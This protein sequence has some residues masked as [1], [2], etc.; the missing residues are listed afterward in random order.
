MEED[1]TALLS[2]GV[3]VP[4]HWRRQPILQDEFPYINL[5]MVSAPT[6]YVL[7]GEVGAQE[8]SVQVDIWA[9][10]YSDAVIL[11]RTVSAL[12]SGASVLE[13]TTNFQG[14][15]KEGEFDRDG[16]IPQASGNRQIFGRSADYRF[17]FS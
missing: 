15:F 1:F 4:V 3:A 10:K 9:E 5:T 14:F 17:A 2:A 7:E 8:A 16:E 12:L 11:S 13:G 6:A